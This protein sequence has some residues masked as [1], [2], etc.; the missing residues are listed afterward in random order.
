MPWSGENVGASA[1]LEGTGIHSA[2]NVHELQT[3][4]GKSW[5][6]GGTGGCYPL[7]VTATL[8]AWPPSADFKYP[9]DQF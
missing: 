9:G 3:N 7:G 4:A 8:T 6:E 2:Q 1:L 5:P